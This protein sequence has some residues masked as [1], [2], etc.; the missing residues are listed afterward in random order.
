MDLKLSLYAKK[1]EMN[2]ENNRNKYENMQFCQ[3]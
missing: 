1:I 3:Q 2:N